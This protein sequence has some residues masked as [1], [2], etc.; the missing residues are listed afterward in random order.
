MTNRAIRFT[1]FIFSS[2]YLFFFITSLLSQETIKH[3]NVIIYGNDI[4]DYAPYSIVP[5][6]SKLKSFGISQDIINEVANLYGIKLKNENYPEKRLQF[7]LIDGIIDVRSKAKEWVEDPNLLYWSDAYI[8]I[9]DVIMFLKS[10]PIKINT[11]DDLFGKTIGTRLG[12]GYQLFEKYFEQEKIIRHDSINNVLLFKMLAAGRTDAVIVNKTVAL[13]TI[14]ENP[15]FNN[16]FEFSELE[17]GTAGYRFIFTK[18]YDWR[19]F[20]KFVNKELK[21]MKE[22]GRLN[23]IID[24]YK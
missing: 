4:V 22:D 5:K 10:K 2:F 7:Y 3:R 8:D 24:K 13:W 14:K 15:E 11:I 16:L 20:I 19:P 6:D 9:T 23:E 18:K 1:L 12:Y 21:L 17:V